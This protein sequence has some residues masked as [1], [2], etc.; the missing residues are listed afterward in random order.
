MN[1]KPANVDYRALMQ[2]ALVKLEKMQTKLNALERAKNEPIAIIGMACR[3]PGGADTPQKFWQLLRDGIDTIGEVPK[4]RWDIDAYYDPDPDAPGKMCT[5]FG[6]FLADVEHFA[7]Q[8]FGIS[9]REALTLDPQQRLLLEVSWEALENA[10]QVPEESS[11][12]GVFIGIANS[13]YAKVLAVAP[14]GL[15]AYSGTGT[16]LSVAAGRLSYTLEFTGPCM[17]IDTACSSSLVAI[18]LACQSLRQQECQMALAGGVNLILTPEVN[19]VFS[20]AR[21]MA[22]DG[23]CKTFDAAAN[24]YVR[25]EGCA[26]I[27]LKRLSDAVAS[28]D[29][30]LALIRGSAVNQDGASG[31]LTVPSGPSQEAVIRQALVSGSVNPAEVSYIEAH[32]TGTSLGD[33][34]EMGALGAVFG[35]KRD[36][37][38]DPLLIGSVKT[39]VGHL[40]AAAGIAGVIKSVLALQHGEIPPHLHFNEPNP[41][42]AWDEMPIKVV[43]E[44]TAWPKEKK[45]RIVGVSSFGFSG[46]NA[47][48][49]LE[50]STGHNK[51]AGKNTNVAPAPHLLA[52]SAKRSDELKA[53]T[54]RYVDGLASAQLSEATL[55]EIVWTA[56]TARSHFNHRLSVVADSKTELREK[57]A[58]FITGDAPALAGVCV[59]QVPNRDPKIAFLFT[60]QGSQYVGMGQRFYESES[61]FRQ[62]LDRCV[63]IYASW[64]KRLPIRGPQSDKSLFDV[65]YP[66]KHQT[67]HGER[68]LLD[69]TAYTQPAL[70]ALE[71][72]LFEVW[73]SWGIEP[74]VVMGHSV[75]EYVAACVAGVFSLEDG[76]K[77]ITARA[78][79]MQAL[80]QIG[81]MVAV[82]A[83]EARVKKALRPFS[84]EVS[85]AAINAPESVVISGERQAVRQVV[86]TL[87]GDGVK[88]KRLNVSHAFHSPLMEPILAQFRRV[89]RRVTYSAPQI[90]IVSNVTGK[91]ISSEMATP[92]YWV[93]HIR[94]AVR[95]ADGMKA[96]NEQEVDIFVEV[97]PKPTLLG[98]GQLCLSEPVAGRN[99]SIKA[100]RLWLPSLRPSEPDWTQILT[101]LGRLYVSGVPVRWSNVP[102]IRDEA[103]RP[104][105]V[106]LP[107]YPFQRE[108]YW[109]ETTNPSFASLPPGLANSLYSLSHS[110]HHLLGQRL[111]L[112][113]SNEIR[114]ESQ[115]NI[116][117]LPYLDHHRFYS[118]MVVPAASH[119][120]MVLSAVKEV[121]GQESC[122]IESLLVPQAFTISD[123]GSRTVQL[124]FKP[125]DHGAYTF[126]L[127]SLQEG[128][129]ANNS[130]AWGLYGTGEVRLTARPAD[131]EP[132]SRGGISRS[133]VDIAAVQARCPVVVSSSELSA[134]LSQQKQFSGGSSFQWIGT[135]WFG[136]ASRE[137]LC[138][139]EPP[140]LEEDLNAYQLYPGVIDAGF[141]LLTHLGLRVGDQTGH[142]KA[143]SPYVMF[144]IE[145]YRFYQPKAPQSKLWYRVQLHD[146]TSSS[147][148]QSIIGDSYLYDDNGQVIAEAIGIELRP[149]T[150][151]A[152][153]GGLNKKLKGW[154]YEVAWHRS[155]ALDR[156]ND[157][158][159]SSPPKTT[160]I[161]TTR[162]KGW[163][164]FADEQG[165]GQQLASIL[166]DTSRGDHCV[167]VFAGPT[168]RKISTERYKINPSEAQDYE[169]LLSDLDS[170]PDGII[171]LWGS[172][173]IGDT[174]QNGLVSGCGSLLQLVQALA[175]RN[176]RSRLWVVTQ[177]AMALDSTLLQVQ[178]APLWGLGRV[179][180]QEHPELQPVLIDLDPSATSDFNFAA[181]VQALA[182][183][184]RVPDQE[185]QL[186]YRQGERYVA[187][188]ART[189]LVSR[190]ERETSG[191]KEDAERNNSYLITGGLGGLGLKV[192][193]FLVEMGTRHLV[194]SGRSG[195]S[196]SAQ[197]V[198]D[199]LQEAGA[200]IQV[201]KADVS[202]L[203]DM[204]R[205]FSESFAETRLRGIIHAAGILDD[206][207]L[208]Q[209]SPTR[210]E[211]VMA[212]KVAGAWNLHTLTADLPL[213]FFVCFSSA[214]SLLGSPA[215]ANYAAANAFM[216]GLAH[217]RH[218][219]GLP[220][221]SINWGAW[222]E[223]GL[224]AQ[225]MRDNKMR[226]QNSISPQQ[227]M[228]LLAELLGQ[229]VAQIAV[230]PTDWDA[231][232]AQFD[233]NVNPPF[234]EAFKPEST[235]ADSAEQAFQHQLE[236]APIGERRALLMAH[237]GD[238]VATVLGSREVID[239]NQGFFDM[240][241]D[242]LMS[243]E[244]RNRLQSSLGCWLPATLAF[245]YSTVEDLTNHLIEEVLALEFYPKGTL[246]DIEA[247]AAQEELKEEEEEKELDTLSPDEI[248]ELL[249]QELTG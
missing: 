156:S 162:E 67:T 33:P 190:T 111:H 101:T 157:F 93:N 24:G 18:H 132:N 32:G 105:Y 83:N 166:S 97:G 179:I 1:R 136:D 92:E 60:G 20:K 37:E 144:A 12:T 75:G 16:T 141:V 130:H 34:I 158:S 26:V 208:L 194:L 84:K 200:Q 66:T 43:T 82:Q 241:M 223:V 14:E 126:Q 35:K 3:F 53:L 165:V 151:R 11:S 108:R 62:T 174:L 118:T 80:P 58:A 212:P 153:L 113:F 183:E 98:M 226:S 207:V 95:F 56:N 145:S 206:G 220:A 192:A 87:A 40:E 70:F 86:A 36:V 171:H 109:V 202:N 193:A 221:L 21:M 51:R 164:I 150:E 230:L 100:P 81:E 213:D 116:Q 159:R 191:E 240:G 135:T 27:A 29:N 55:A 149:V 244:L 131:P 160:E 30:I 181:N 39:N 172:G 54:A 122:I 78:R 38:A 225:R 103:K 46:T 72:A 186:A 242:S 64:T 146:N 123:Q 4:S 69:Q 211:N 188:L 63:E 204:T 222:G 96:I 180:A 127:I 210:F 196:P 85:I 235:S 88:T 216:D 170:V 152:L 104:R 184:L 189:T 175:H 229:N 41:H 15:S 42:I 115:F 71:Y 112:P 44:R 228:T 125:N 169:R 119:I 176:W 148:S 247:K 94:Q 237:V 233:A 234:L 137:A 163:L 154:L 203:A 79:L 114:F 168:Y 214:A 239:P 28:G 31:G 246:F 142:E 10:N 231:F 201:I 23:R 2:K 182:N 73:T 185:N 134:S 8:F 209:Q 133:K 243:V 50:A 7:P 52:L 217:Y 129:E 91:V 25:G 77:L 238:H 140:E 143:I 215:Q 19:V 6:G 121:F 65:I 124:V 99:P 199:Q 147:D 232:F 173:V 57:L 17:A 177:G 139:L 117:L 178:Q 128:E 167:L 5:R 205:L 138:E 107:T 90:S 236:K 248:A 195:A 245:K 155:N 48:I 47:H 224:A 197:L 13:D 61:I 59:G 198:I 161:V 249:A 22:P 76:L 49:V 68:S 218:S 219:L 227:G 106:Q 45:K 187:R 89:A 9:P 74:T 102:T 120:S 110:Y